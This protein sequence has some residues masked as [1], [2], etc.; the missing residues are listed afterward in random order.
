[1]TLQ[2]PEI[3]STRID[4]RVFTIVGNTMPPRDPDDDEEDE[5]QDDEENR[6]RRTAGCARAGRRLSRML[7]FDLSLHFERDH[8]QSARGALGQRLSRSF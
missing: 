3:V 5:E 7:M 8:P 2:T 4:W 6:T 1:M